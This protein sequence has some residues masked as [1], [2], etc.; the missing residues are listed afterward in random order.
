MLISVLLPL[1]FYVQLHR[2]AMSWPTACLYASIVACTALATVYISWVD[3]LEFLES[4]QT[5]A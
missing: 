2:R 5:A 4:L 3:V 1:L